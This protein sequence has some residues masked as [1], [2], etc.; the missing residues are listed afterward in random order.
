MTVNGKIY[1]FPDDGDVFVFYYRKDIFARA[2]LKKAFKAKYKYDLAPPKTWKQF[3]EIGSFLTDALKSE[4]IYGASF[5][6][7]PTYAQLMFQERF[8][9][10][11][12]KFFDAADH[13]GDGEQPGRRAACSPRCATRTASCRRAWRSSASSRTWRCSSTA[14]AR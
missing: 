12:G 2:D 1:G 4:G 6:R 10:E 11:G 7:E 13:E 3:D 5:F 14:R 9:N 8:R